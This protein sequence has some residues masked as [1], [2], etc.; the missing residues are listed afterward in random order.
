MNRESVL[1]Y[2]IAYLS[3]ISYHYRLVDELLSLIS[4]SGNEMQFFKLLV[5]RLR[6]LSMK[7]IEAT[8]LTEF[9]PL[10]DG[11]YSMHMSGKGFN[12]RI[13]YSF[14][15]NKQPVLLLAFYERGGKR[16]TDYTP[17]MEP[18]LSRLREMKEDL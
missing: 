7:G 13:I 16:R 11:L 6:Q 15:P 3:E 9:E 14:L 5:L 2:L 8:L 12:I 4:K 1:N 10:Q 17:H 18:A